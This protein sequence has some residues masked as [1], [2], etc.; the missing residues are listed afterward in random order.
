[1][2]TNDPGSRGAASAVPT[3]RAADETTAGKTYSPGVEL[4]DAA[5]IARLASDFFAA[6]PGALAVTDVAAMPPLPGTLPAQAGASPDAPSMFLAPGSALPTDLL[7]ALRVPPQEPVTAS[8]ASPSG[9]SFYFLELARS[10][11]AEQSGAS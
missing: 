10:A 11:P 1:M 7:Q 5:V 4:P 8:V 6:L 3:Q 2:S 9:P